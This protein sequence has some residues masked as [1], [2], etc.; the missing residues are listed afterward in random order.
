MAKDEYEGKKT[1]YNK[2]LDLKEKRDDD[3]F[4]ATFEPPI[5]MPT[6]PCPPMAPG[7]QPFGPNLETL[8]GALATS[9]ALVIGGLTGALGNALLNVTPTSLAVPLGAQTPTGSFHNRV[10]FMSSSPVV[11][12]VPPSVANVGHVWGRLGQGVGNLPG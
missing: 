4:K 12:D 6:R 5:G 10:L 7:A 9:S 11:G 3:F 1:L 2:A 8:G